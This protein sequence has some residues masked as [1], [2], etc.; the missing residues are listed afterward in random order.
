MSEMESRYN[1]ILLYTCME[2][3]LGV[4]SGRRTGKGLEGRE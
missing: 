3:K 1:R 4:D 2:L